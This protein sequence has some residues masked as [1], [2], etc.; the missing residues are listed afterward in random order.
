KSTV[1]PYTT[2]FRSFDCEPEKDPGKSDPC[3]LAGQQTVF[4]KVGES[5]KVERALGEI[6]SQERQQHR[7]AAE[8]CVEEEL[9]RRAIT[10]FTAPDFDQQ[11][12]RDQAH[13][14]E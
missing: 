8:E 2:L 4:S 7:H 6:N 3:E 1:F 11:K 12:R 9:G 10:I 13:F 14:V 5:R